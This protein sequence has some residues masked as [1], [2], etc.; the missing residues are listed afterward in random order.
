MQA[1]PV[2]PRDVIS[3]DSPPAYRVYFW[4]RLAAPGA[5]ESTEFELTDADAEEVFAWART[6]ARSDQTYTIYAVVERPDGRGLLRLAGTD[7]TAP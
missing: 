1:V 3:E 7:P 5:F 2:D 6:T 4:R